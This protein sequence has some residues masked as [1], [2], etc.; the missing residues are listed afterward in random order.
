MSEPTKTRRR[1]FCRLAIVVASATLLLGVMPLASAVITALPVHG[2]VAMLSD[3]GDFVGAGK[4]YLLRSGERDMFLSGDASSLSMGITG[5]ADGQ[6]FDLRFDAPSGERLHPG[7]YDGAQRAPF[8]QPGRPGLA[9]DANGRGCNAA[10]GRFDVKDILTRVDGSIERLWLTFEQ[11]C[12]RKRPALFGEVRIGFAD[13]DDPLLVTPRSL[14]WPDTDLGDAEAIV[15]VTVSNQGTRPITLRP[16]D[17]FGWH[18]RDF[19]LKTDRCAGVTLAPGASCEVLVGFRPRA[20][21]PRVAAVEIRDTSGRSRRTSLDGLGLGSRTRFDFDSERGDYIG[22]GETERYRPS[23]AAITVSGTRSLI[24]GDIQGNDG[25]YWNAFFAAP[26]GDILVEGETYRRALRYPFNG[27]RPGMSIHGEGRGCNEIRGQFT[28]TALGIRPDGSVEFAGIRFEQHCEGWKPALRG[29]FE[30]RVPRGDTR[31][32]DPVRELHL[33]RRGTSATVEWSN[34]PDRDFS[35]TVV[36]MLPA[37]TAPGSP[38]SGLFVF[39][40]RRQHAR[41]RGLF[42]GAPLTVSVFA[43]DDAGNVSVPTVDRQRAG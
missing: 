7:L 13:I 15:P 25:S 6:D 10:S 29:T 4:S 14:W 23:N 41:I 16:A 30:Y 39:A 3:P 20:A 19:P 27:G 32:T 38:N 26:D 31:P 2:Y 17:I 1:S 11:H 24:R 33:R 43:V 22:G 18:S 21:G 34:P 5:G 35:F 12:E 37:R 40:G 8:Q 42:R 9:I 36:R 28:V